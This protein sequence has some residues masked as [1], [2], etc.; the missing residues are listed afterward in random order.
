MTE[1][2]NENGQLLLDEP[3]STPA[4]MWWLTGIIVCSGVI[5]GMARMREVSLLLVGV[6]LG[7]IAFLVLVAWLTYWLYCRR[8]RLRMDATRVWSHIPLTK[9]RSLNWADVRT[10]AIVKLK[11][12]NYPTMIVLSIHTPQETLTRKRMVWKN[13]KRGEEL[14]IQL[15][16][17]R[18][19]IVEQQL[20]MTLPEITL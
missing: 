16:D 17:S 8:M 19:A 15:T 5:S 6:I 4:I 20:G 12:M 1:Y 14:R 9:D 11:D 7:T 2:T 3:L 13:P 18:R 10:A